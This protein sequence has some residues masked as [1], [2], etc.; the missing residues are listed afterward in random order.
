MK[1]TILALSL[2]VFALGACSKNTP[3][4]DDA[5][6]APATPPAANVTADNTNPSNTTIATDWTGAY[7]GMMPCA[8][9]EGIETKL[10]LKTNHAYELEEEYKGK[11][12]DSK[13]KVK[14]SYTVD[15]A[16]PAIITLDQAGDN[17][18]FQKE[19]NNLHMLDSEGKRV[20]GALASNYVL[21]RD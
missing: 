4:N 14:G 6:Q 9:C 2:A 16:N 8:D 13:F 20:E 3:Q 5:M 1:K 17:R 10:E 21:H 11:G 12:K 7:K 15:A 18:K 19:G